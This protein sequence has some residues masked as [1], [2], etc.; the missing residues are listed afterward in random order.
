MDSNDRAVAYLHQVQPP[1]LDLK[2]IDKALACRQ[3]KCTANDVFALQADLMR[4]SESAINYIS[5]QP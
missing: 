2:P 1:G 4:Q 5:A 3:E